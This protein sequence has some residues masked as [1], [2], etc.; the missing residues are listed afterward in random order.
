MDNG[1]PNWT[2]VDIAVVG[3][4]MMYDEGKYLPHLCFVLD[5]GENT[6]DRCLITFTCNA[7]SDIDYAY[8][9]TR[10]NLQNL[11]FQVSDHVSVF[12]IDGDEIETREFVKRENL[13]GGSLQ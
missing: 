11:G 7:F 12:N 3:I 8:W 9:D 5:E 6:G 1:I 10:V 4:E 2:A 13:T